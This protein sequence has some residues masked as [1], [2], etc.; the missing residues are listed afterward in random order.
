MPIQ[1][2]YFNYALIL[3]SATIA[4]NLIE[5]I[6]SVWFGFED[7]ALTLFGFG[8]DSFVETISASGILLMTLRLKRNGSESRS[9]GEMKALKITGW[10]FY[11]LAII[12]LA[13]AVITL[14]EGKA[15]ESTLSG[16]IIS[17]VSILLMWLLI[18]AKTHVGKKLNSDA[19]LADAQCN[20]V[21]L[22]MSF[23]L[24]ASS[25]LYL[26]IPVPWFDPI[27][28]LFLI[29]FCIKE[30]KEAFDKAKGI[31]CSCQCAH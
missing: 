30:G 20:K 16:V 13:G 6:I 15:P 28:A 8:L 4:Y 27:G 26:I 18:H 29:W 5:G 12:L 11:F 22:Y 10:C 7:E 23:I 21:C 24:L 9:Q 31:A 3:A 2:K 19:I 1:P 17:I 25:G 14:I